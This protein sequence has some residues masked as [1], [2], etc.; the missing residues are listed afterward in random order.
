MLGIL[1]ITSNDHQL[2]IQA[3][4]KKSTKTR[5]WNRIFHKGLFHPLFNEYL[6]SVGRLAM[7]ENPGPKKTKMK[8]HKSMDWFKG[9]S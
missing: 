6:T 9:K 4:Q 3:P 7:S 5:G 1:R 2:G 8:R